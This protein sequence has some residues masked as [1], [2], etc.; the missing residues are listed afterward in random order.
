MARYVFTPARRAALK[1]AQA[2]SAAKRRGKG[3]YKVAKK[4]AKRRRSR[5]F[6]VAHNKIERYQAKTI[7]TRQIVGRYDRRV[8]DAAVKYK[9][10]K[11]RSDK[12]LHKR[13]MTKAY[14]AGVAV[15]GATF[16]V[17]ISPI[18][19]ASREGKKKP[20]ARKK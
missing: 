10:K 6:E 20:K 18:I 16:A 3:K 17:G 15:G 14:I 2:K 12:S 1:R 9:G 4:D 11:R 5:E 19:A 13:R 7:P 8:N